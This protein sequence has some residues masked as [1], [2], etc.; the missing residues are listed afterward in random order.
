MDKK[1]SKDIERGG[2]KKKK[3]KGLWISASSARGNTNEA[4]GKKCVLNAG[5]FGK[6]SQK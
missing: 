2:G 5:S 1:K 3:G 6:I 4:K